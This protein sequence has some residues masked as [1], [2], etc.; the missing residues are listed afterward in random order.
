MIVIIIWKVMFY[1]I[2]VWVIFFLKIISFNLSFV[3]GDWKTRA[4]TTIA[5]LAV[6]GSN[7]ECQKTFFQEEYF[8]N[9]AIGW[10]SWIC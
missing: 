9:H 8:L 7:L 3:A 5:H 2:F 6:S 4:I 10:C 1:Y